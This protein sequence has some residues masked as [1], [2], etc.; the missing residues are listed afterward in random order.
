V[1]EGGGD[2]GLATRQAG[3]RPRKEERESNDGVGIGRL[4]PWTQDHPTLPCMHPWVTSV[5]SPRCG[6]DMQICRCVHACSL[7]SG[8]FVGGVGAHLHEHA[9]SEAVHYNRQGS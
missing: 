2:T 1:V 5:N 9:C 7:S 8:W 4:L 3:K 6:A